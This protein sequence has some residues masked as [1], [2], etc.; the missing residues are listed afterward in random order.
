[1]NIT[2]P[3]FP[4][5]GSFVVVSTSG[6]GGWVIRRAT[7]SWADHALIVV[8]DAGSIVEAEPGGV[9]RGHL[10]EYSGRQM[11]AFTQGTGDQR[12]RVAQAAISMIGVPYDDLDIVDIGLDEIGIHW[13]WLQRLVEKQ[14]SLI[15]SQMVAKCGAAAGLDWSCGQTDLALVTPA[16]LAILAEAR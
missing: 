13:G 15:C 6:F 14:H 16:M 3:W 8:D 12:T 4:P 7:H 5:A 1:M 9:R 10:S 11:K 2:A